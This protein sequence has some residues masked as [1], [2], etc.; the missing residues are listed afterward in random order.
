MNGVI[1]FRSM[2]GNIGILAAQELKAALAICCGLGNKEIAQELSCSPATVKKSVERIF[3]KLGISSRSAVPTELFC[4]GIARRLA[5]IMC[6]VLVTNAVMDDQ[7]FTRVRRGG[8]Q[9]RKVEL[10]V[11]ARRA[12]SSLS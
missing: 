8:G 9:G 5:M 4:R 1:N 11:A 12:D 3:Y 2:E 10:R 6:A 7:E